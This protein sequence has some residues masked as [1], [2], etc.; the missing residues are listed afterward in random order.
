M[1]STR[2]MPLTRAIGVALAALLAAGAPAA[3][4]SGVFGTDAGDGPGSEA[5]PRAEFGLS[6][7][8]LT[9]V[10]DLVEGTETTGGLQ[11]ST[12][13]GVRGSAVWWLGSRLALGLS[14]AWVSADLDRLPTA[15]EGEEGFDPGGEVGES[16]YLA[17]TAEVVWRL[18]SVGRSTGVEPYLVGGVGLRRL[19]TESSDVVPDAVTDPV[20]AVEAGVTDPMVAVGGGFRTLLSSSLLLRLEARDQVSS[21]DLGAGSSVQH[22]PIVSVGLAVRP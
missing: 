11:L 9:P 17:G 1:T 19:S 22:D 4:Q 14:A 10:T 18:S 16:D 7:V 21:I 3:G 15:E 2:S 20:V 5:A 6:T 8:L 12:G 13:L